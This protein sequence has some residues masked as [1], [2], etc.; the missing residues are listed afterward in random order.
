MITLR[1]RRAEGFDEVESAFADLVEEVAQ[2]FFLHG[3]A[4]PYDVVGKPIEIELVLGGSAECTAWDVDASA[5]GFFAV[6]SF[7]REDEDTEER[8][9]ELPEGFEVHVNVPMNASLAIQGIGHADDGEVEADIE[10][11]LVTPVHEIYHALEWIRATGGLTPDEVYVRD[12]GGIPAL[13]A[14]LKSIEDGSDAED[15]VEELSRQVVAT[16]TQ[17]RLADF[18]ERL[19]P[20][21][22]ISP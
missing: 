4:K 18:R 1:T 19:A 3:H 21:L 12:R 2:D 8:Y 9:Y 20:A 6:C 5:L 15:R 17:G 11:S 16:L 13:K 22:G 7:E 14:V 10:A